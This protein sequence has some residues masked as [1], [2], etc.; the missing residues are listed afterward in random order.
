MSK[1]KKYNINKRQMFIAGRSAYAAIDH[2]E[3]FAFYNISSENCDQILWIPGVMNQNGATINIEL[4]EDEDKM[5]QAGFTRTVSYISIS[6]SGLSI[7]VLFAG[8]PLLVVL[9]AILV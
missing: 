5:N 3:K 8:V 9:V 7:A 6:I 4:L 2:Y 1:D